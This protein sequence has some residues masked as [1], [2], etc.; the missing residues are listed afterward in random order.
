[1]NWPYCVSGKRFNN[2]NARNMHEYLIAHSLHCGGF[3][4]GVRENILNHLFDLVFLK[5]TTQ[6]T[7]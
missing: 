1:M 2:S 7:Y 5:E 3:E 4:I 6:F